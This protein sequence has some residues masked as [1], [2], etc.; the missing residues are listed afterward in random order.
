MSRQAY[1]AVAIPSVAYTDPEVA[2]V[3]LT[4]SQA[5]EAGRK[6]EVAVFPWNVSGRAL[7]NDQSQGFT[8]LIFDTKTGR[9]DT[10]FFR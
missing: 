3:G 5:K 9:V 4:E 6:V 1:D 2:W 8:K 10:L 7:A